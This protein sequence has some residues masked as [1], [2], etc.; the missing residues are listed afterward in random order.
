MSQPRQKWN[1][2][3][4]NV[5]VD[6]VVL[7]VDK[8]MPRNRWTKGRVV[9]VFPGEDGLVRHVGVRTCRSEAILK[10]PITKLVVL[11]KAEEQID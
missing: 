7:L 3:R 11:L 2:V 1:V 9:E 6:D 4:R 5:A 8:D 10:R